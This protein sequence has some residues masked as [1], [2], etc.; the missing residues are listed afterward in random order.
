MAKTL[1][2]L[3]LAVAISCS[4]AR[5]LAEGPQL[6]KAGM[7]NAKL[8]AEMVAVMQRKWPTDTI[9]KVVI[10]GKQWVVKTTKRG[11]PISRTLPAAVA[12]RQKTKCRFFEVTFIQEATG[13]KSFGPT[14][15]HSVGG[16]VILPCENVK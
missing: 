2:T 3:L 14:R 6:P 8:A 15:Y 7:K 1:V 5:A 12:V 11:I 10:V 16:N 4:G 13:A 9:L